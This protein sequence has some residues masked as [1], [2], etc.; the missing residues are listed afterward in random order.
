MGEAFRA[1][2]HD[3]LGLG[4]GPQ[5]LQKLPVDISY[6]EVPPEQIRRMNEHAKSAFAQ[7]TWVTESIEP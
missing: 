5:P 2:F 3:W 4:S 1:F 6:D 7:G